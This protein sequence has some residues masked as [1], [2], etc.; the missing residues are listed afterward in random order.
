MFYFIPT[1][2]GVYIVHN[3][4]PS[5]ISAIYISIKLIDGFQPFLISV[6]YKGI[7]IGVI[8]SKRKLYKITAVDSYCYADIFHCNC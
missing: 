3:V 5:I 8:T 1:L 6:F 4:C 2:L 7:N